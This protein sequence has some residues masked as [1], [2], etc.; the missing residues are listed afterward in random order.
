ML[1]KP[2]PLDQA[3]PGESGVAAQAAA[4]EALYGHLSAHEIIE[5]AALELFPGELAAVS[6]FGADSAVLLHLIAE[7]DR[8]LPI[9]F[10]DT[11]K[12]FEETFDY[13]DA[14]AADFGLTNIQVVTPDEAALARIDPTGKLHETNTDACCDVRKV[15]PMARGV[16]PYRAWFTGRKRFQASTRAALPAFEAVGSRIRINPLARFTTA[17]QA[18]Y[19]RQHA[20][21]E[22]PLVAYGYLSIGCFPCTQPVQPGEDARSGRWAGHAKT[23][24]GIHLSGLEKSLT[25]A[26]L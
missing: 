4:F 2:R 9:V 21:R 26:S 16:E 8:H 11:G 20:L 1:A 3:V 22:N 7:V 12:H 5:R 14:L 25:D 19:M 18:D 24:C 23:E 6:S 10:L 13:R 17:D 15:E